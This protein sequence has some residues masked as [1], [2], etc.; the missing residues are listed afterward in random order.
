MQT[1]KLSIKAPDQ[2]APMHSQT[3]Y[4]AASLLD[5]DS[6]LQKQDNYPEVP[7]PEDLIG[8]VTTGNFNLSEGNGTAIGSVLLQRLLERKAEKSSENSQSHWNLCIVRDA[9]QTIGR[10]A[11]LVLV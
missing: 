3:A 11:R 6:V 9:G 1:S 5:G 2:D 10:L 7:K 8:F 4:M